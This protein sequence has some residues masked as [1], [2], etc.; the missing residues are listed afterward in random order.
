MTYNFCVN[1]PYL[2]LYQDRDALVI[3][4]AFAGKARSLPLER[5]TLRDFTGELHRLGRKYE[6]RA[7]VNGSGKHSSLLR[8]NKTFNLNHS[9]LVRSLLVSLPFWGQY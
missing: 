2:H 1:Y 8:Y 5:S 9:K 6:T 4:K 3:F 7:N